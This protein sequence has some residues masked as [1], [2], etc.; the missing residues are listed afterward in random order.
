MIVYV[1]AFET[2]ES[3]GGHDWFFF[4]ADA[5]RIYKETVEAKD[6][7]VVVQFKCD[8]PLVMDESITDLIDEHC[9]Q[10]RLEP[11]HNT[12]QKIAA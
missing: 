6:Y 4:P 7:E 9:W 11:M 2:P 12:T 10:N 5:D 3:M 8:V 1:V